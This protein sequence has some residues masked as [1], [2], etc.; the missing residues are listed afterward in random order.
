[1]RNKARKIYRTI[2]LI[3]GLWL[4]LILSV[5]CLTG[6]LIVYKPY[7]E[8]QGIRHMAFVKPTN[9]DA[10]PLP[11]DSLYQNAKAQYPS[12]KFDNLVLYGTRNEAYSFRAKKP[13]VK[14]RRQLYVNQYTGVVHGEDIYKHKFFQHVYNCHTKLF[15]GKTGVIVVASLGI[16]LLITI[17]TGLILIPK[18]FKN[19]L[20]KKRTVKS[21]FFS[22]Y[23]SHIIIGML[24]ALPL[25]VI[26]LTGGYWGFPNTYRKIFETMSD[27]RAIAV[28][29]TIENLNDGPYA[30]LD[31]IVEAAENYFPEGKPM[32]VFFPKRI[33]DPFS[34]RMKTKHDFSRTGSNHVYIHPQSGAVVGSNLWKNKPTAEKLTRSM[35]FIHFGEFWGHFSRILWI[36]VGISVPILYFTGF[37]LWWFKYSKRNKHKN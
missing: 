5:I 18:G 16:I 28:R 34:V 23:K 9:P 14:G 15:M 30:S 21:S 17:I 12:Y 32:I 1:M 35:Y 6:A 20:K 19:S 31:V 4:G 33:N 37:Y 24:V 3:G 2:H 25:G 26:A 13:K 22:Y 36:L 29:P 8:K 27:G 7:L 11:L 10:I